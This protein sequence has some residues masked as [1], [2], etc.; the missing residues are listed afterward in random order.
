M[1]KLVEINKCPNC[2]AKLELS[3]DGKRYI[4]NYCGA[5]FDL[6]TDEEKESTSTEEQ[7]STSAEKPKSSSEDAKSSDTS[8]KTSAKKD[9]WGD[10]SWIDPQVDYKKLVTGED[11][12]KMMKAFV[13]C[14]SELKTSEQIIKY[15]RTGIQKGRGIGM[16]GSNEEKMNEFVGRVKN[17]LDPE[18]QPIIYAN[19]A[20]FGSGK[21]GILVTD[22]RTVMAGGKVSFVLHE[23]LESIAFEN[24]DD[25]TGAYYNG[26]DQ[27]ELSAVM[28]S[29][30]DLLGAMIALAIAFSFEED[31]GR[32]KVIVTRYEDD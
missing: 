22:K 23:D 27:Y 24:D 21:K 9:P 4:C 13:K 18:E 6:V 8:K 10:Q 1:Q 12:R 30:G 11:T 26:N 25:L 20:L 5:E 17:V 3:A 16:C 19:T 32:E 31:P 14:I 29:D 15:I 2:N 7:K 28:D